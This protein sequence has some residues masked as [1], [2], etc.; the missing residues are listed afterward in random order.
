MQQD[1]IRKRHGNPR[2]LG[3]GNGA[4]ERRRQQPSQSMPDEAATDS[5]ELAQ[6]SLWLRFRP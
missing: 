5:Q 2:A 3:A 6:H 1:T 4:R